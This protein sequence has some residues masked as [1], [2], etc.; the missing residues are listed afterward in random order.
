MSCSLSVTFV[1]TQI[2]RCLDPL[3]ISGSLVAA[4]ALH[5]GGTPQG[6]EWLPVLF[7]I[8]TGLA[9][10]N[11]G[12][13]YA[14]FGSHRLSQW[15]RQALLGLAGVVGIF[16]ATA[17]ALGTSSVF[18]R[19]V[20]LTWVV[21]SALLLMAARMIA[22]HVSVR[23]HRQGASIDRVILAGVPGHCYAFRRHLEAHPDLGLQ[24]V[25]IASDS[26][27][28][29]LEGATPNGRLQDLPEMIERHDACRVI[30]CGELSDQ[31]MV[32]D[33][34]NL[35]L[36]HPVTVQYAPDYSTFP[37]FT[38]RVGDCGGRPLMDLSSSPLD[39]TSLALKWL[40]DK[41]LGTAILAL[42][43]PVL[44][45]IAALVKLTSPGPV[46]FVQDRHGLNGKRIKVYKF[47]TMHHGTPVAVQ[48][49]EGGH[50]LEPNAEPRKRSSS[51]RHRSFRL[52]AAVAMGIERF[53]HEI[54]RMGTRGA[55]LTPSAVLVAQR[56]FSDL[57]PDD[58]VQA[59]SGDPRITP[60]GR[61]LRRTSLDELPQ[62]INVFKGDMSIV[63]PRPHAI[64]HNQQF[65]NSVVEL[66]R[67]HYVKPGI[68]GLAQI[69][70]ARG[71]TRSI[72]DM[73]RRITYDLDY[74]RNWSLWLDMKIICLTIFKGFIN[75]QP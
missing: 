53:T 64:K 15:W 55:V 2:F 63:G 11:L 29:D 69:N 1:R 9:V 24:V 47:R 7:L 40:E 50:A 48:G 49:S 41:I 16:L 34:M 27:K 28:T 59:T 75:R 66:M 23:L 8:P 3:L 61:L 62:F 71:E 56:R 6:N 26:F 14:V 54:E 13:G 4:E 30:V 32:L 43:T 68:T 17:Y 67:R 21:L 33:V 44:A 74:I 37:I 22:H 36:R 52:E 51:R 42:I 39:E 60:L 38:F 58:F 72:E 20:V 35:L 70:G 5:G 65:A 18:P 25:G 10:F 19:D 46:F 45:V 73:R 57:A 31:K 12:S